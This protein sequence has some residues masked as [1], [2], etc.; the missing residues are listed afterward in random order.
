MKNF[1]TNY[2]INFTLSTGKGKRQEKKGKY[3]LTFA[4]FLLTFS[5]P[6]LGIPLVL[7]EA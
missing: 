6:Q 3:E 4:L 7:V 2:P 1:V 5:F